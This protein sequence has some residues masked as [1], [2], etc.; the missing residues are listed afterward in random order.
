MVKTNN[1]YFWSEKLSEAPII[2][3]HTKIKHSIIEDYIVN[4]LKVV[5]KPPVTRHIKL[6]IID[7]FCGGGLYNNNGKAHF[8][9]PI[10]IINALKKAIVE[11]IED[12]IIN[13][14]KAEIS[15][16]CEI[17]YIDK[18]KRAIDALKTIAAPYLVKDDL[19]PLTIKPHFIQGTFLNK[20]SEVLAKVKK[21]KSLFIIDPCG[22]SEAPLSV[23]REIMKGGEKREMIWTFMIDAMRAY[24]TEDSKA[25][26]NSG[27]SN[28]LGLFSDQKNP[29]G[30]NV[31]TVIFNMIK[32][33]IGVPF[34]T[35]FAIKQKKGW[36]Y[37]LIHLAHHY[38]ASEVMKEVEHRHADQREHY[39]DS[40]LNM[41]A[42]SGEA[43]Y[44][45][46]QDDIKKGHEKLQDD[47]PSFL[48]SINNKEGI[49]YDD[50]MK[51]AYNTTPLTSGII[52][53]VLVSHEDIEIIT[54]D[55]KGFRSSARR[56]KP[57]DIIRLKRQ[58]WLFLN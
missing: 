49:T 48:D 40:G 53:N 27:Y 4:Y 50:F 34:F 42:K 37:W 10:I 38:R 51:K 19:L 12:R 17:F 6:A 45:F 54:K 14:I 16:D 33:D 2:E 23:L 22:Y 15:V 41:M 30:F 35:P 57:S 21:L 58:Q 55:T 11:I 26:I 3:A 32:N 1:K 43:P 39:G 18:D 9:T 31:Q 25:L 28:L 36:N 46:G 13:N 8:G 20:Y 56:I 5:A 7:G 29:T 44:L 52:K 47:I 24:A